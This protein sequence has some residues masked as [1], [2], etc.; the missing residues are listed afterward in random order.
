MEYL[1][2]T[3]ITIYEIILGKITTT[4]QANLQ[5]KYITNYFDDNELEI[6]STDF[7]NSLI[8]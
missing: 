1:I 6:N 4:V 5:N 2:A 7:F 8:H 3:P